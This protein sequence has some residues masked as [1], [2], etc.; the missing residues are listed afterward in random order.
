MHGAGNDY[1]FVNAAEGDGVDYSKLAVKLSNRRFSV[2]GDGFVALYKTDKADA[3]MVIYNADGS[4]AEIC[5]NALRCVGRHLCG[6]KR[7]GEFTVL[8]D[9]GVRTVRVDGEDIFADMGKARFRAEN[10][11]PVGIFLMPFKGEEMAFTAVSV[12]NP[13]AVAI[14][15][16]LDFDVLEVAEELESS[17]IFPYGVNVEF[18]LPL[19][20]GA[21]VR[22]VERGSG[23][24]LCCGS[25]AC[26]VGAALVRHGLLPFGTAEMRFK[27]GSVRVGV[28][29]DYSLTLIG[30]AEQSFKGVVRVE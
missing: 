3:K 12:G 19:G 4:R 15:K 25:G 22:V 27:G 20:S 5:G 24:T 11:P 26:A 2:G 23:E 9:A 30:G 16:S 14:V 10:L 1:V 13:H 18:A 6:R 8:T 7:R 21:K 28:D 29:G 17:G